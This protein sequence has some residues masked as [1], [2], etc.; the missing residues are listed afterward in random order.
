[1]KGATVILA[2]GDFPRE[3]GAAREA[4]DAAE[5]VVCCDS[6]AD[7][8]RLRTGREPDFTVG[9]CDS[10]EGKFG[11]VVRVD[12]QET[13]DLAKA[14][15]FCRSRGWEKPLILGA[16]GK[17]EDH[18]IGNV[19]LALDENVGILTDRGR[20]VPVEGRAT[21]AVD[22]GCAISVFAPDRSTKAR[23]E[24]LVWPL[25]GVVF[26]SLARAT[27]NRAAGTEITIETDRRILV[28]IAFREDNGL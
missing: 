27:L 11:N 4:L 7:E 2:A 9:D 1:M 21:L 20:F 18:T 28:Y 5:R 23:S 14:I 13:N 10:L 19:F 24:G 25:D 6:A 16:C 22:E 26:D 12:E 17:R 15:R 8:Y 3:G